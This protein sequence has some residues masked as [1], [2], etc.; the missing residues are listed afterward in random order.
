MNITIE[1]YSTRF[2]KQIADVFTQAVHAIS[3]EHYSAEQKQAWASTPVDYSYWQQRLK[4]ERCF[5][6][7][8]AETVVGFIELEGC[9]I[10]CCYVLP[11]YQAKG[12]ALQMLQY[13]E[14]IARQQQREYLFVDASKVARRFFVKQGFSVIKTNKVQRA[15][16]TLLNFS[17]QKSL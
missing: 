2:A 5:V 3:N 15:G 13:I 17:M 1:P 12:I 7:L 10:D 8:Q 6:A 11:K 4:A 9:N 14:A 16:Q